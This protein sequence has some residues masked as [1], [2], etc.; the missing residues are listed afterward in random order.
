LL[1]LHFLRRQPF[2]RI[3]VCRSRRLLRR[4]FFGDIFRAFTQRR[5]ATPLRLRAASKIFAMLARYRRDSLS[6]FY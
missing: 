3:C 2:L 5:R 1:T 4:L 6:R